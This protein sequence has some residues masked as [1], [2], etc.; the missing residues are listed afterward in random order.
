VIAQALD[1][2]PKTLHFPGPIAESHKAAVYRGA[3]CF[4]FPS[5]YEGFGL[6]PLEALSCGV[7]VVGSDSSSIPEVVGDAGVLVQPDDVR[8]MAGAVIAIATEPET[9]GSLSKRAVVQSARFSW[10][11][12]AR[13]TLRGY[14]DV[15][16]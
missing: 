8:R 16:S 7:P 13:E 11:K 15:M 2:N 10:G 9:R 4:L 12:T 14:Q 5:Q 3:V 1:I 6:P